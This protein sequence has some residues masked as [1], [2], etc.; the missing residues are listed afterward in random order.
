MTMTAPLIRT[1]IKQ[2]IDQLL[3]IGEKNKSVIYSR[4]VEDFG[5]PRR[6][7][8][9]IAR[10]LRQDWEKKVKI[11]ESDIDPEQHT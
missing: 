1:A 3:D 2:K 9:L 8:R 11:L 10:E 5:I 4:I 7:V 6:E